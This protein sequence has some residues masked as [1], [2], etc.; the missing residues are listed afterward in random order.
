MPLDLTDSV[1]RNFLGVVNLSSGPMKVKWITARP[2][3]SHLSRI[4]DWL[5]PRCLAFVRILAL[6]T[7]KEN[8]KTYL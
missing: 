4:T 1:L 2:F 6:A 5:S 8:G 3:I 7:S